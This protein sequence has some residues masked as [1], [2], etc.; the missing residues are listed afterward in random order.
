MNKFTIK[1]TAET[2]NAGS[3]DNTYT[4]E[5]NPEGKLSSAVAV[6]K[7]VTPGKGTA[8]ATTDLL[9]DPDFNELIDHLRGTAVTLDLTG[10]VLLAYANSKGQAKLDLISEN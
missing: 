2:P 7:T 8:E 4:M 9:A 3:I 5:I 10:L 1:Y 6:T